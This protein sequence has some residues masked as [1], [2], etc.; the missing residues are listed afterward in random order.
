MGCGI[1]NLGTC[2]VEGF[3]EFISEILNAPIKPLLTLVHNLMIEPVNIQIF[4]EIWA[5]V[6][7]I[8]SLF[9][10]ILLVITGFR[11]MLSGYSL[12]QREKAKRSL[13]NILIMMV[14]IQASFVLYSIGIDVVSSISSA[15]FNLIPTSFF[16]TE[17]NSLSNLGLELILLVPYVLM[18]LTTLIFLAI[19]YVCV[20]AG[21]IFF[22]IGIFFYFIEPLQSYG[23]LI[24]NYLAVLITL[25]IFYSIILLTGSK[26]LN[27]SAFSNSKIILMTATFAIIDIFT[28]I[29]LFSVILKAAN[30]LS[31]PISNVTKITKLIS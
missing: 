19:R 24:I 15:I 13:S 17:V 21:V 23:K 12:E 1:T 4:A 20:S 16:S 18:I 26:L 3:F 8:L 6:I 5:I 25:P 7:S 27:I 29:L 11:F 31:A 28:M 10:G 30:S 14:L 9:Y 22:A 2:L